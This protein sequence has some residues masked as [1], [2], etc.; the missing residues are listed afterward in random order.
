[1]VRQRV[2][3]QTIKNLYA[4]NTCINTNP[5]EKIEIESDFQRGDEETGVWSKKHK[6]L[7]IDS[8]QKSFPTGIFTF[9]KDHT[10]V[11]WKVV[12]GGNRMRAIRDFKD[13]KF[14]D[15]KGRKFS[16]LTAEEKADFNTI[17]IPSLW[18]TIEESDPPETIADMFER[19]NTSSKPLSQGELIKA[20]GW[21][22]NCEPI[23]LAKKLVGDVWDS[24]FRDDSSKFSSIRDKWCEVFS[25]LEETRRCDSLAM[26]LG[27]VISAKVNNFT[28]FDKRYKKLLPHLS[29]QN[30]ETS[31]TQEEKTNIYNKLNLFLEVVKRIISKDMFQVTKGIPSQRYIGPIWK[32][33][34][35][36][37]LTREMV[38]KIITFHNEHYAKSLEVQRIYKSILGQTGETGKTKITA[39]QNYIE[40]FN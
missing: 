8:L 34:C 26:M 22:K 33:V 1:M 36:G 4:N 29:N 31:L 5:S 28:A 17:S 7:Y 27:Y 16:E 19:L 11:S 38:S 30:G 25:A 32:Y 10:S 3:S 6:V 14:Q 23:E 13:D 24:A 9:V 15:S 37:K 18:L 39:A 21:K 40:S 12:D 35:E 2:D 20:H